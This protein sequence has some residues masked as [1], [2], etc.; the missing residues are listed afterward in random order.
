MLEQKAKVQMDHL[1]GMTSEQVAARTLDALAAGRNEVTLSL[2]GKLLVLV[3]RLLPWLVDAV[4]RRKVRGLFGDEISQRR[5]G[6][7]QPET[8]GS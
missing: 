5:A 7:Q 8:V 1:R 6:K 3:S 2:K 4:T